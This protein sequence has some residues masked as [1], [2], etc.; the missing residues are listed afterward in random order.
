M[1]YLSIDTEFT[2][3]ELEEAQLLEIGI[4]LEDTTKKLS[5]EECPKFH[6]L[7]N[8]KTII[9]SPAALSMNANILKVLAGLE[10]AENVNDYRK[11]HDILN[12]YEIAGKMWEFLFLNNYPLSKN[13]ELLNLQYIKRVEDKMIPDINQKGIPPFNLILAGKNLFSKDIP[14]LKKLPQ[15]NKFMNISHRAIDPAL[16]FIDWKNDMEVPSLSRCKERAKIE[17]EVKHN[18]LSDAWDIISLLRTRY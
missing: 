10:R 15:W 5:Y 16:Y 1:K 17:G 13:M 3:L 18:A 9:G 14:L 8:Y 2:S 4:I 11:E 6:C 12:D 7:I